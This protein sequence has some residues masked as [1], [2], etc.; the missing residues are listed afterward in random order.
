MIL[1]WSRGEVNVQNLEH[2]IYWYLVEIL[3]IRY[4]G[5][6]Q[7]MACKQSCVLWN[8]PGEASWNDICAFQVGNGVGNTLQPEILREASTITWKITLLK[9]PKRKPINK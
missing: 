6:G 1:N 8:I 5:I 3:S 9:E 7:N 2:D 4:L